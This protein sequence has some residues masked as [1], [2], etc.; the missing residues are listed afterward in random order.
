MVSLTPL[1]NSACNSKKS[2]KVRSGRRR[3]ISKS[4]PLQI[5]K[6]SECPQAHWHRL[7]RPNLRQHR[8]RPPQPL[9]ARSLRNRSLAAEQKRSAL[10]LF[11]TTNSPHLHPQTS[12]PCTSPP[13]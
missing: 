5:I 3:Q 1:C 10:T 11:Q 7:L 6:K 12:S 4:H 8:G 9:N 2:P 13:P